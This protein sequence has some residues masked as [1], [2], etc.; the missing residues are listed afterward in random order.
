MKGSAD[1]PVYSVNAPLM[2]TGIDYSD[3]RSY[4][5]YGYDAAMITDTAFYRNLEYHTP[6]DTADRLNYE[7]MA[8]AV[9]QV[10]EAVKGLAAEILPDAGN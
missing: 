9:I 7:L 8:K 5:R 10:F 3:H 2:V 1:L 4:W 6:N